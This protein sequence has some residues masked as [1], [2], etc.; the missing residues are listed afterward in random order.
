MLRTKRMNVALNHDLQGVSPSAAA[1]Q[2]YACGHFNLE[3]KAC[4][5]F[6]ILALATDEWV[7]ST[8]QTVLCTACRGLCGPVARWVY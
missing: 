4:Q 8:R 2:L 7:E 6:T 5:R 3:N 1:R